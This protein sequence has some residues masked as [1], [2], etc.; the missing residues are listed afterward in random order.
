MDN[1]F[2]H[3]DFD[4]TKSRDFNT[5]VATIKVKLNFPEEDNTV[6]RNRQRKLNV[7]KRSN[8]ADR[9]RYKACTIVKKM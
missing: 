1:A 3:G 8:Y 5:K 7:L 4:G 6:H 2:K 9:L